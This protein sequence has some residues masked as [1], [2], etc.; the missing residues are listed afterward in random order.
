M[1]RYADEE[2]AWALSLIAGGAEKTQA[3]EEA[4]RHVA[5]FQPRFLVLALG[6]DTARGDPTGSWSLR[7]A[8]F[9]R[10]GRRIARLGRPTLVV[11]EGGYN[12]RSLGPAARSF[13]VG[14]SEGR[15]MTIPPPVPTAEAPAA[16]PA[17]PAKNHVPKG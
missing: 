11:Q 13:F 8:D 2:C 12:T 17:L 1:E 15:Q 10:N 6:L 14:L 5:K 4:L 16:P 3:L 9:E 7:P